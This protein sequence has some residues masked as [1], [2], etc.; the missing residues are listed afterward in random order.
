MLKI[1]TLNV[2]KNTPFSMLNEEMLRPDFLQ[3][4]TQQPKILK[5]TQIGHKNVHVSRGLLTQRMSPLEKI[6]E[7]Q[8]K[9]NHRETRKNHSNF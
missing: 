6:N 4:T 2:T 5:R 9:S 3:F 1:G 8:E 7:A